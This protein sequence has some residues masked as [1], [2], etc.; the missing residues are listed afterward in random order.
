MNPIAVALPLI[1]GS[2]TV[3]AG[4]GYI[5]IR[6]Q[7]QPE[8]LVVTAVAEG[9][10][11][12]R[13]GMA[14]G[15]LIVRV[16]GVNLGPGV[17][18]PT[19]S[20]G[21]DEPVELGLVAPLAD[22]VRTITLVRTP[23]RG[24]IAPA[25]P[26][27]RRNYNRFSGAM[28][29]GPIREARSAAERLIDADFDGMVPELAFA[30]LRRGAR[31]H[32]RKTRAVL[33]TM[34]GRVEQHPELSRLI[35]ASY[36]WLG[37]SERAVEHLRAALDAAPAALDERLGVRAWVARDLAS[38]MW[39]AGMRKE[40]IDLT[41]SSAPLL[42][43]ESLWKKTGMATPTPATEWRVPAIPLDAIELETLDG[44]PWRL[45]Q[46]AG[47]PVALV[48]WAS[49][50]GPCKKELPALGELVH[51]RPD[52][53][54][55][56]M[57]VSVDADAQR[58]RATALV[59]DWKLPFP[60]SFDRALGE[61]MGV[62]AL[63]A[64]RIIGPNGA[65]RSSSSGYS[66][67]SIQTLEETLDRLVADQ[68]NGD[69]SVASRP[70]AATWTTGTVALRL[71]ESSLNLG[72]VSIRDGRVAAL[73]SGHGAV[74]L[75]LRDGAVSTAV[76][77]DETALSE[78]DRFVDW[79]GG[80]ISAGDRWIRARNG[81]GSLRWFRTMESPIRA[82]VASGHQLWVATEDGLTVLD[83]EG[84][85]RTTVDRAVR[86]VAAASDG[87]VWAVDG[88]QRIR[89]SPDGSVALSDAAPGS[90]LIAG[91]G[92]WV[93]DGFQQLVLGRFGPNGEARV[94]GLRLDG[95][96]VG[97][98]GD[99][100]PALRLDVDNERGHSLAIGDLDDDGRDELVLS[101]FG[102]G[103]ATFE[104]EIP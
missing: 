44:A 27:A 35:G 7:A 42:R 84:R 60:V 93:G 38:A 85:V 101:S 61:R 97:L 43:S 14:P 19:L 3:F 11:A 86:G 82:L 76:V 8:G 32:P 94:V 90:R 1:L 55:A 70:L 48:F 87:G 67:R 80:P 88:H 53:P 40:S 23:K 41:R 64:L 52:W 51:S 25:R 102:H 13:A 100:H 59:E 16:D 54:V 58:D 98:G 73:M 2:T 79:F 33:R 74:E 24:A 50:C 21:V 63:P 91:D 10:P 66:D 72:D 47:K 20:G 57:A 71:A 39:D 65:L 62:G 22:S 6:Y 49:W 37:D 12:E 104:L 46:H 45:D 68:A 29:R 17:A 69:Q 30:P 15:D 31:R 75:P 81:D 5:G 4:D 99:G 34:A 83:V 92:S 28:R 77:A 103:V 36:Q 89:F 96:V 56:L 9:G 78:W 26:K 18:A 95:T